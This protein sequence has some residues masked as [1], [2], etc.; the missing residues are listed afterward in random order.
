MLEY[1]PLLYC[2]I[3]FILVYDIIKMIDKIFNKWFSIK[4]HKLYIELS[5]Y[6]M[7]TCYDI[8]Y[9]KQLIA[10]TSE[11]YKPGDAELESIIRNYVKLIY[12]VL[13]DQLLR[14]LIDFYGSEEVLISNIQLYI[15]DKID[16]DELM[17]YV[18]NNNKGK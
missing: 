3:L 13:G 1:I 17:S 18:N 2:L 9:K 10:F 4:Y 16:N 15:K 5:H 14:L 7:N 6:Y 8:I 12:S 11:G